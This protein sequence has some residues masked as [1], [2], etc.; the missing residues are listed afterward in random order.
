MAW[1][2]GGPDGLGVPGGG[3]G[4]P[5]GPGGLGLG[6]VPVGTCFDDVSC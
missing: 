4:G 5:T 1:L 3:D 6:Q 2:A